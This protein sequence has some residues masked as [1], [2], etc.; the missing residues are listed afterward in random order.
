M[1]FMVIDDKGGEIVDKD[2]KRW[3]GFE[4]GGHGQGSKLA[5]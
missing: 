2:I 5:S 4:H 1:P 3:E